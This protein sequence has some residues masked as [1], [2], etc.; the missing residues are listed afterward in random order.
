MEGESV[1]KQYKVLPLE[2]GFMAG[3]VDFDKFEA[4]LNNYAKEG[5]EY[6]SAVPMLRGSKELLIAIMEKD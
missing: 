1:M 3:K 6:T 5:W 2:G 4:M